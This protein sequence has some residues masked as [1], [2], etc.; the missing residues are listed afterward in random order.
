MIAT[1]STASVSIV[2]AYFVI[3]A[4]APVDDITIIADL[5]RF[6]AA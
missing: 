4:I 1:A 2:L 5:A 3:S 6:S